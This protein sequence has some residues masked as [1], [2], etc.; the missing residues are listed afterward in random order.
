[1]KDISALFR[2]DGRKVIIT[3]GG[4]GLG[5][6]VAL[7]MALAGADVAIADIRED[8]SQKVA[9][10]IR[11]FGKLSLTA[12]VDITRSDEVGKMVGSVLKEFGRIDI[13][14]NNA[15]ISIGSQAAQNLREDLWDRVIDV[16]LKGVFLCSQAVCQQMIKQ[17]GGKIINIAS[18][19]SLIVPIP[20]AQ[21]APYCSS[22][23]GVVMLTKALASEWAKHNINVNAVSPGFLKTPL[24]KGHS[25]DYV[26]ARIALTPLGRCGDPEDIIGAVIFLASN[27]SNFITGHNLVVD[28]GRTI[29]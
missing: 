24:T 18:T 11:G 23:A 20:G 27:A 13:L 29:W 22:K 25:E 6:S 7:A 26:K 2:L 12:K 21:A 19:A 16:N 3:G 28:G 5:E 15:G 14:V 10:I 9:E 17:G 4:Q 8:T 1:M